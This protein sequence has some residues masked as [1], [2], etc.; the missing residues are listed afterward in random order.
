[1]APHGVV[2]YIVV[3][4][5][6]HLVEHNHSRNFWQAVEKTMPDYR[7]KKQWLKLN[8]QNLYFNKK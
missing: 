4:E 8:G 6:S 3:H 2:D 5:L 1:M 7:E